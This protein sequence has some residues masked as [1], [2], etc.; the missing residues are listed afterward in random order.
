MGRGAGLAAA[1]LATMNVAAV[2]LSLGLG[3]QAVV[4]VLGNMTDP[5]ALEDIGQAAQ[6]SMGWVMCAAAAAG[7]CWWLMLRGKRLVTTDITTTVPARGRFP[8]LAA[9]AGAFFAAQAINLGLTWL[10]EFTGVESA[11][12]ADAV[13]ATTSPG[14]AIYLIVV[15]PCVEELA[16]RG[17]LLRHLAPHGA[18]FAIV[19]QALIFGLF[20]GNVQQGLFAFAIGLVLGYVALR[21]SLKWSLLLHMV[22][23]AFAVAMLVSP[24]VSIAL[25]VLS[26]SCLVA[27]GVLLV[28]RRDWVRTLLAEGRS[29]L[30]QPFRAGWSHPGFIALIVTLGLLA[31]GTTL[32]LYLV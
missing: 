11:N 13:A 5:R 27:T 24:V 8:L 31:V 4:T 16:F 23:N 19:T 9:L 25:V 22:N 3:M 2:I 14:W 30:P 15:A 1:H 12:S 17:A 29:E 7:A 28:L 10:V 26:T 32:V 6:T 18:N 20:H 21:F